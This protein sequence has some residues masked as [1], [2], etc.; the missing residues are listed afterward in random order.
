MD[1]DKIETLFK[2][3]DSLGHKFH[4]LDKRHAVLDATMREQVNRTIQD[5]ESLQ[6]SVSEMK[7]EL[8]SGLSA[9]QVSV[10]QLTTTITSH[11]KA[12]DRESDTW[13]KVGRITGYLFK[14]AIG[15]GMLVLSWVALKGGGPQ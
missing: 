13:E 12:S 15:F 5:V 10:G 8:R 1:D 11:N 6:S 14:A 9:V 4:E 7:G 2:R 3:T